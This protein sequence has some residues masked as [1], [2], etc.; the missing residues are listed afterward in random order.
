MLFCAVAAQ[1]AEYLVYAGTSTNGGSRGIYGYRFD[2][3]SAKLKSLGLE[4][5]VSNP[6]FLVEHPDHRFLYAVSEN[7][8]GSVSSF[9]IYPK[10][11]RL[12]LV[13]KTSSRGDS[14]CHLALD[15]SGRWLAVANCGTGRVAI[16]PLRKDGGL[17]DALAVVG[18]GSESHPQ[19]VLFSP[20]NR[21]LLVA[22]PGLDRIYVYRFDPQT[23]SLNPAPT[24]YI[25]ASP[26]AGVRHL[27]FHPNGRV[28][29]AVEQLRPGVT[30]Y[31]YE[32]TQGALTEIQTVSAVPPSYAGS[33]TVAEIAVNGAGTMVYASYGGL[34]TMALLVVDPVRFT[35]SLLELTPLIGQ[36]P[37]HFAFD[38]TGAFL[39]VA[40]RDSNNITL[41][42]VHPHT[43]QLR[44]AGRESLHI[45]R[46]AS[47]VFVPAM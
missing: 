13:N 9:V 41:Y 24:P 40:N 14:P 32:P 18:N 36:T 31:L 19:C 23:G 12:S 11:G 33:G 2:T 46:P 22:D 21:F 43:G 45:E 5:I 42:T 47:I 38:P 10:S 15:R 16:F 34:D 35:L 28:L 1:G 17:G 3:G 30:V 37:R 20:D 39:L 7:T 6:T 26:G 27:A 44:P 25:A 29:Y 8:G 4:A